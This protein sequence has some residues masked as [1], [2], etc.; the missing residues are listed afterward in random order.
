[1]GTPGFG[2]LCTWG[3]PASWGGVV[4]GANTGLMLPKNYVN[5]TKRLCIYHHGAGELAYSP[6]S[7]TLCQNL[8]AV[9]P[10][11]SSDE[12]TTVTD[13]WGNAASFIVFDALATTFEAGGTYPY[14]KTGTDFRYGVS[15]G[16]ASALCYAAHNPGSTAA[17][18]ST[19]PAFNLGNLWSPTTT[20]AAASNGG[21]ITAIASW[22]F[23]SAGVLAIADGKGILAPL[24]GTT[25]PYP[26]PATVVTSGGTASITYTGVSGNTLTGCVFVSGSGTVATGAVVTYSRIAGQAVASGNFTASI[27]AAYGVTYNPATTDATY[28]GTTVNGVTF[29]TQQSARDVYYM[30]INTPQL[31]STFPIYLWYGQQDPTCCWKEIEAW[32]TSVNNYCTTNSLPPTVTLVADPVGTHATA[33]YN[34]WYSVGTKLGGS[35]GTTVTV[36]FANM[37]TVLSAFNGLN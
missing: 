1:M 26:A 32:A 22:A 28:N 20:V 13:N 34:C 12:G 17:V 31:F 9:Y 25:T 11:V 29:T 5:N 16:G 24:S 27:N 4:G 21:T 15:M 19:I 6:F 30:G 3:L 8:A 18:V 23:P 36:P 37:N 2:S 14:G 7:N 35:G 10:S 33:T